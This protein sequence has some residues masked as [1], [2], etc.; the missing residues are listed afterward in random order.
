[1]VEHGELDIQDAATFFKIIE[2]DERTLQIERHVHKKDIVKQ[3]VM[4][5]IQE[6]RAAYLN[7]ASSEVMCLFTMIDKKGGMG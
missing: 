4:R 1:M 7:E 6:E 5:R 3:S 2:K